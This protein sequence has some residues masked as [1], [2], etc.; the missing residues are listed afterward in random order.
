MSCTP[1]LLTVRIQG[2]LRRDL[3]EFLCH[4]LEFEWL[5]VHAFHIAVFFLYELFHLLFEV[6]AD[7]IYY[8]SETGLNCII[9]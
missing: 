6:L 5:S 1:R 2:E 9:D 7:D 4:E 3:E 8:L